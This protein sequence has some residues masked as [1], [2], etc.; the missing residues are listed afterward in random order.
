MKVT[1]THICVGGSECL[2]VVYVKNVGSYF[3]HT[4]MNTSHCWKAAVF[5]QNDYAHGACE[6]LIAN[7]DNYGVIKKKLV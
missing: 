2:I 3:H 4:R 1:N 5:S 7:S 6:F